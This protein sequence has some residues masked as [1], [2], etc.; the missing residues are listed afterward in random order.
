[1]RAEK[2]ADRIYFGDRSDDLF[3]MVF[4]IQASQ[5]SDITILS[6]NESVSRP[7]AYQIFGETNLMLGQ[8]T[9]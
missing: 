6:F 4:L 5:F 3:A 2:D 1:M 8:A 7:L 9:R